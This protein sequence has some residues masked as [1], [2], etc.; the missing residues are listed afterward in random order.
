VT[1][2]ESQRPHGIPEETILNLFAVGF[3]L[4]RMERGTTQVEDRPPWPSAWFWFQ[5]Q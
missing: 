3:V 2:E 1:G 4:E 5:R